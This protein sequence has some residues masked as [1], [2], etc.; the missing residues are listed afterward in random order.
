MVRFRV[1][2]TGARSDGDVDSL[3]A[4]IR[5]MGLE[6]LRVE[7]ETAP[8][9][10]GE[11]GVSSASLVIVGE[12]QHYFIRLFPVL[13]EWLRRGREQL[14][15]TVSA[16][17]S[18]EA[19]EVQIRHDDSDR[20]L[21]GIERALEGSSRR[22]IVFEDVATQNAVFG[23][24]FGDVNAVHT[25]ERTTSA[26]GVPVSSSLEPRKS[27][28]LPIT[29]F[30]SDE[31]AHDQVQAAVEN[32]LAVVGLAVERADEPIFGSWFRRMWAGVIRVVHSPAGRE[33]TLV[34]THVVD[35]H[36]HLAQDAAIAAA[37]M[38]NLGPVIAALE[39]TKDAVVRVGSVVVVKVDGVLVVDQLT[40]AQ[41]ALLD[42]RPNLAMS[43]REFNEMLK[44]KQVGAPELTA[45]E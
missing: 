36:L 15:L 27:S 45:P 29:I 19:V 26:P 14:A 43:P 2:P 6:G 16:V 34:A 1:V 28:T 11:P 32:L 21:V 3:A 12:S 30:L 4:F 18:R 17:A 10:P 39:S 40:A 25:F 9:T 20:E 42:H 35:T 5:Q 37:L 22:L 44:A 38:Q 23:I 24:P 33:A 41:Q 31:A 7:I 8:P 13:R